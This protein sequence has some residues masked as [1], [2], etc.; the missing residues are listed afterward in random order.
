MSNTP[1]TRSKP[2]LSGALIFV[3]TVAG[4]YVGMNLKERMNAPPM[5]HYTPPSTKLRVGTAFPDLPLVDERGMS[6]TTGAIR[7]DNGAVFLF[8]E[9]GCPPCLEMTE[10][11]MSV[12]TSGEATGV[13]VYGIAINLPENIH[14][15]RIKR[16]ITFPVYSD[17]SGVFLNQYDVSSYPTEIVVGKSG[18]VRYVT[19][20]S[21]EEINLDTLRRQL[22]E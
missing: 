17:T 10:K 9:I 16:G 3:M 15:Y 11:W 19:F 21:R 13:P 8:M 7:G 5:E 12:I 22:A 2:F 4:V 20:D 1:E 14:P 6:V 18:S